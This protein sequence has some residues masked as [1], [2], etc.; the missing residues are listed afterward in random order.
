MS[1]R[2]RNRALWLAVA[3]AVAV[4]AGLLLLLGARADPAQGRALRTGIAD[5]V[6]P[7]WSIASGPADWFRNIGTGIDRYRDALDD[8]A[9]LRAEAAIARRLSVRVRALERKNAQLRALLGV[10][11]PKRGWHRVVA[12]SGATSGSYVR[13][14]IVAGGAA[15]GIA[16]GQ[17]VRGVSG[18]VG[19]VVET[20]SG[21]ARVL[22]L[23]DA[24]SRV[25]VRVVRTG[26]PAMAA[27][28]NA[29][30]LDI[31]YTAPADDRLRPGD[32][33]VTSG[34]GGIFPPDVPVAIVT[35][36]DGDVA[37]AVPYARA[38]GLGYVIVER[39]WLP[40]LP[41]APKM[42]AAQP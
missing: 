35:R 1:R 30:A 40:P 3:S 4:L 37:T 14:A 7:V 2:D 42:P 17:P 41:V 25:P 29:P 16:V 15:Q 34:D 28:V 11:E 27:G 21:S 8:N 5:G 33:L 32:R 22:L 24:A 23:T 39:P 20:G 9:D 13:S 36:V 31:R 38:E 12:I 18:L 26:R 10:V 6:S 19:R